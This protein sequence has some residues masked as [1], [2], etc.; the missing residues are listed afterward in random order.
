M[1][2]FVFELREGLIIALKAVAANKMRSALTTVGI[3]IGVTAVVLMSTAIKGI[4][5][6][7]EG[8]ISSLGADVLYIAK[9]E[10]FSDKPWWEMRRRKD[11]TMDEY[12]RF[13]QIVKLPAA[14][15]PYI[16]ARETVKYEDNNI[17]S[18]LVT[19]T[20]D[21]YLATTNFEFAQGRFFTGVESNSSRYV[22]VLGSTVAENLFPRGD[23]LGKEVKIGGYRFRVVGVLEEQGSFLLG[24]FNPDQRVFIPIGVSFKH[25]SSRR[26]SS[27]TVTVKAASPELVED[28]REEALGAM[29]K[30]RGLKYD[31]ENDFG[32]NQQDALMET[33]DSTVGVIQIGGYFITG[34]SLFVGAIG[35]M[36]IMFVSVRERTRE[37]GVRKAIG[38][39]RRTIL[40]Q[41]LLES[42]V[43]CVMGGL[44]GLGLAVILSLFVDQVLPTSVQLDAAILAIVISATT[45]VVAGVAPA[46]SAAKLD[47]VDALRYE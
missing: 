28:T 12:R 39:K 32:I 7:F 3:V 5:N 33:Y 4:D 9:W 14:T 30:V 2:A 15:A 13:A 6:A 11:I 29:R 27:L 21:R 44:I 22:A 38:A 36:N 40:A 10:W 25:F 17:G 42:S 26:H 41:F 47:P 19:G 16:I 37:I 34:L 45:G 1:A 35:I 20:T 23:A 46:Y 8:G 18:A 31:D 43:I 24:D